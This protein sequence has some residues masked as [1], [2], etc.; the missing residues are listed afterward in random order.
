MTN[1]II[2]GK[3]T[4]NKRMNVQVNKDKRVALLLDEIVYIKAANIYLE[5]YTTKNKTYIIRNT[6]KNFLEEYKWN[7]FCRVHKSYIANLTYVDKIIL[8]K[9]LL[10]FENINNMELVQK[11]LPVSRGKTKEIK[12]KYLRFC[13]MIKK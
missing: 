7:G 4:D 10:R 1:K 13:E 3:K 6:M 9:L 5:I 2:E 12:E 8:N 11:E